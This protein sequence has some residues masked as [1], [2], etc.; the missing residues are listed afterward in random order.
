MRLLKQSTNRNTTFFMTSSSDHRSGVTGLMQ[1]DF[2]FKCSKD[3]GTFATFSPAV[4]ELA[5]G[6]YTIILDQTRTN[7][8]GDFVL[9]I[10]ATGCDPHDEVFQVVS[11]LPGQLSEDGILGVWNQTASGLDMGSLGQ[12][13]G[14]NLDEQ[15]STRAGASFFSQNNLQNDGLNFFPFKMT[16][17][18]THEPLTG[19]TPLVELSL[20]GGQFNPA[21]GDPVEIGG[22]WYYINLDAGDEVGINTVYILRFSADGCDTR[23]VSFYMEG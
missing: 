21:N 23:E 16:D 3:G 13:V 22:G 7:T 10:T 5:S 6:W 2:A 9:H 17:A 14:S 18:T 8:L 4:T 11:E 12:L 15:V 20:D 19:L 1:D